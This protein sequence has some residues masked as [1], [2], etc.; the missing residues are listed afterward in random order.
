MKNIIIIISLNLLFSHVIFSQENSRI[1]TFFNDSLSGK[2]VLLQNCVSEAQYCDTIGKGTEY[3]IFSSITPQEF[4]KFSTNGK[5][6]TPFG[7]STKLYLPKETI[8][9]TTWTMDD[10]L[11]SKDPGDLVCLEF[12]SS[13][14]LTIIT[15]NFLGVGKSFKRDKS[16]LSTPEVLNNSIAIFPNPFIDNI[17]FSFEIPYSIKGATFNLYSVTGQL[18]KSI[19]IPERGQ[20]TK[21]FN[22]K[23]LNSGIYIGVVTFNNKAIKAIR[24][25][26]E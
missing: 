5:W 7:D 15:N 11:F 16:Y 4:V 21:A 20:I 12:N 17:T 13:D 23:E 2:W 26:K 19:E 22:L 24:L 3:L 1:T 14:Y 9:G 6:N 8:I 25:F 10:F 18:L